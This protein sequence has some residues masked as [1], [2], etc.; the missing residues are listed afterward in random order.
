MRHRPFSW[1]PLLIAL[2]GLAL[3]SSPR[4]D[5]GEYWPACSTPGQWFC[6]VSGTYDGNPITTGDLTTYYP[7]AGVVWM[8]RF[9]DDTSMFWSGRAETG[10]SQFPSQYLGSNLQ[11]VMNTGDFAPSWSVATADQFRMHVSGDADAGYLLTIE[12][13]GTETNTNAAVTCDVNGCGDQTTQA[14]YASPRFDGYTRTTT[15][16]TAGFAGTYLAGNAQDLESPQFTQNGVFLHLANPHLGVDGG[17]T[18]GSYTFWIPPSY[19]ATQH[20]TVDEALDGGLAVERYDALPDAS[21]DGGIDVAADGGP[22]GVAMTPL[23]PTLTAD[24]DGVVGTGVRMRIDSITY[25]APTIRVHSRWLSSAPDAGTGLSGQPS[26]GGGCTSAGDA[27]P[28]AVL[29]VALVGWGAARSRRRP[30]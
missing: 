7:D 3:A 17:P 25:S 11:V 27:L 16:Q 15:Q 2:P 28:W 4:P 12:G 22:I 10:Y 13:S 9:D 19:L 23:T 6:V 14:D 1:F 21:T 30:N 18:S 20:L 8:V 29:L 24:D 26:N 5:A